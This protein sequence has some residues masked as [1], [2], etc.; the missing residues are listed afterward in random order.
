MPGRFSSTLSIKKLLQERPQSQ[1]LQPWDEQNRRA[2]IEET[3]DY[4]RSH[5]HFCDFSGGE[6]SEEDDSCEANADE[7]ESVR[8]TDEFDVGA[9]L[10]KNQRRH[11]WDYFS[12]GEN[13][14]SVEERDNLSSN[15]PEE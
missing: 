8:L 6:E 2:S 13:M 14:S 4:S 3:L 12:M 9:D 1:Q 5:R 7:R 10:H 11:R 15:F